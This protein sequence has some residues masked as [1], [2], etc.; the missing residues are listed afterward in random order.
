LQKKIL[1]LR[2]TQFCADY[3]NGRDKGDGVDG[4]RKFV[5]D[6]LLSRASKSRDDERTPLMRIISGCNFSEWD[7]R[8]TKGA[9]G[10]KISSRGFLFSCLWDEWRDDLFNCLENHRK[11]ISDSAST[12]SFRIKL[13]SIALSSERPND[14]AI[15]FA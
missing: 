13:L 5:L 2:S 10:K 6:S 11:G 14:L 12:V 15:F 8:S 7:W 1:N 3:F 9:H 4:Y